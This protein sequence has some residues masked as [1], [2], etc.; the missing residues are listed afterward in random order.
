MYQ[1]QQGINN[2]STVKNV[3]ERAVPAAPLRISGM[4]S[5]GKTGIE[6]LVQRYAAGL[7]LHHL[8]YKINDNRGGLHRRRAFAVGRLRGGSSAVYLICIRRDGRSWVKEFRS[9]WV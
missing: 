2:R 6:R 1:K 3:G 8:A 9:M 7:V 5:A 4:S